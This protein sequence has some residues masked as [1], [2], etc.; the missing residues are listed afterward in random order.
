MRVLCATCKP[1]RLLYRRPSK[2]GDMD[3]VSHGIC[4]FHELCDYEYMNNIRLWERWELAVRR[5]LISI[6]E[7]WV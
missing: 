7:N 4:R 5:Y 1:Q 6:A 3:H 2:N